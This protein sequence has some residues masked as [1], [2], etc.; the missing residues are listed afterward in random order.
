MEPAEHPAT[1]L[2]DRIASALR[3]SMRARDERRTMTL[4]MAMAAAHN[5]Q[6]E[7]RR[8]LTDADM[9]DVLGRQ[10]KQRRESIEQYRA[11]GREQQA[12]AEEA[13]AAILAEYLPEALTSDELQRIVD[14]AIGATGASSPSQMGAVMGRIAPQIKG[15]ADGRAVSELVRRLLAESAERG[16]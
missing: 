2:Q 4:R 7:L 5:K 13:E 6:I 12:A 3:D 15:R 1:T 11:G 8:P 10:L 16:A 9:L 14:D